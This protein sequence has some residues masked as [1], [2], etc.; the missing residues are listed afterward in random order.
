MGGLDY[1]ADGGDFGRGERIEGMAVNGIQLKRVEEDE[2]EDEDNDEE[3]GGT[4]LWIH[5]GDSKQ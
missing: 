4:Q 1:V 5:V 2:D 3:G